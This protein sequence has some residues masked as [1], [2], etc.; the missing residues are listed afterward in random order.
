MLGK[1]RKTVQDWNTPEYRR[2]KRRVNSMSIHD[3]LGWADDAGTKMCRAFY[4]YSN[5]RD[6]IIRAEILKEL[7]VAISSMQAIIEKL[8][9]K[10][11]AIL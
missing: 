10:E 6:E 8:Q 9:E 5:E 7:A 2:A 1:F 11:S 3:M 4:E